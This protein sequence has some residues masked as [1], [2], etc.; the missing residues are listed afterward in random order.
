LP[1]R[2]EGEDSRIQMQAPHRLLQMR[3]ELLSAL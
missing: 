3:E 1:Q 2:H